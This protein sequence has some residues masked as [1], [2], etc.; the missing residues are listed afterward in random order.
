MEPS[1][2]VGQDKS[3]HI[4]RVRFGG[5]Y[6]HP[7]V[8]RARRV[9]IAVHSSA[10]CGCV[11]KVGGFTQD[12]QHCPVVCIYYM[13]TKFCHPL[14]IVDI[15]LIWCRVYAVKNLRLRCSGCMTNE[16]AK[17]ECSTSR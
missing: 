3:C 7:T 6:P 12:P 2:T 17:T 8:T 4:C 10:S 15:D 11:K 5:G 9:L 1:R 13:F 16:C 14:L